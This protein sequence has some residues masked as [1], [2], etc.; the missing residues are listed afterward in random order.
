MKEVRDQL[1]IIIESTGVSWIENF[2]AIIVNQQH[3]VAEKIYLDAAIRYKSSHYFSEYWSS[4]IISK[5]DCSQVI[6][7]LLLKFLVVSNTWKRILV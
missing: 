1:I 3:R 4:K 6:L 7:L 2:E 5:I